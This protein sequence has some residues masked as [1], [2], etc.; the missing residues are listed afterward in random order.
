LKT[1]YAEGC[2]ICGSTWGNYWGEIEGSKMFFCCD[3]CYLELQNLVAKIKEET[4]WNAI[5]EINIKG[6]YAGR[7]CLAT[8][9]KNSA[10]FIVRFDSSGAV[11]TFKREG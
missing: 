5:D 6:N 3:I 2:A 9:D 10:R 11:Q 7:N 4:G 8:F 1:N